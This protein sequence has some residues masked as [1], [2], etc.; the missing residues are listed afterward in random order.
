M[1]FKETNFFQ[2]SFSDK[3]DGDTDSG[4]NMWTAAQLTTLLVN[5]NSHLE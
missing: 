2:V 4:I 5:L 1:L 3:V